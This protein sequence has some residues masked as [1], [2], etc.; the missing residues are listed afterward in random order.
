LG[1]HCYDI[2]VSGNCDINAQSGSFL[3]VSS[4]NDTGLDGKAVLTGSQFF[5]V[6]II[7]VFEIAD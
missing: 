3:G 1:P 5:T 7:E 6:K 4:A 2:G